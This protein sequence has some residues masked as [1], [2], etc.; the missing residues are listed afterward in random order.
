MTSIT[1][2]EN[3]I[4]IKETRRTTKKIEKIYGKWPSCIILTPF[5]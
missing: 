4:I 5:L 2:P 1:E 3:G